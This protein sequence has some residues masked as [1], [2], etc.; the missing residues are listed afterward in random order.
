MATWLRADTVQTIRFGPFLDS[1]DAVTAETGLT[2]AQADRQLSKDGAAFAQSS[3]AGNATHDADGWYS[4]DISATDTDTEGILLLQATV[5]GALPVWHEFMV[6]PANVYDSFLL[7]TDVLDVSLTQWI[8][9]APNA[10]SS[11]RVDTTVVAMA[12]G[13]VTAAAV[14]TGAIDADALATDAVSEIATGV[15]DEAIAEPSAIF[16]WPASLRTIIQWVGAVGRNRITQTATTQIVRN[17]ADSG[18]IGTATVSD[19]ATTFVR[20]EFS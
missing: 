6:M 13:T 1:T 17:D 4:A 12:A 14:A 11:G 19:D 2:I 8:G 7:G 10:L 5:S 18:T 15:L 9:V 20:G 3:T 16:T